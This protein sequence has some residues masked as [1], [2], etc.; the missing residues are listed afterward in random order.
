MEV[1]SH[2][3]QNADKD[4]CS[5][6]Y[7][8]FEYFESS[9]SSDFEAFKQDTAEPVWNLR[10]AWAMIWFRIKSLLSWYAVVLSSKC[11]LY[12]TVV[13]QSKSEIKY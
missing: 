9:L 7:R 10:W 3:Q 5:Q 1:E 4:I 11:A 12:S 2:I 8:D 13:V 6:I